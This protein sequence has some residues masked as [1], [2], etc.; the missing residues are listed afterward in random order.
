MGDICGD[1]RYMALSECG[2]YCRV[3]SNGDALCCR[4]QRSFSLGRNSL[5]WKELLG[6]D[7]HKIRTNLAWLWFLYTQ[8]I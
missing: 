2:V 3:G 8:F 7:L 1:S 4:R 5:H 6:N